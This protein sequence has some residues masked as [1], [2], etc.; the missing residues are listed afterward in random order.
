MLNWTALLAAKDWD[1][2][3]PFSWVQRKYDGLRVLLR[4]TE[5]GVYDAYTRNG[6]TDVW[7]M[8]QDRVPWISYVPTYTALDCE[9][10]VEGVH[11]TSVITHLKDY[12]RVIDVIPF[13]VPWF[14]GKDFRRQTFPVIRSLMQEFKIPFALTEER[15][16]FSWPSDDPDE[17][18]CYLEEQAKTRGWEGYILK[19]KHYSGW[20]KVKP[21]QTLDLVVTGYTISDSDSFAGGVKAIQVAYPQRPSE[22]LASVGS[23]FEAEWRMSVDPST[24]VGRVAEIS[25]DSFAANGG[26]KFPRFVRWRDDK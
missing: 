1:G 14:C 7:P 22:T 6:K 5:P 25:F 3:R 17:M 4:H 11:A 20:W 8:L 12:V 13:A 16:S 15:K 23:G 21:T 26:L 2:R 9:V 10:Y 18:R 19:E 24:L